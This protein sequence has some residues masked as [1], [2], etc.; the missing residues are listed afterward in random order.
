MEALR[1]LEREGWGGGRRRQGRKWEK[2]RG[3]RKRMN[4]KTI[5]SVV[6]YVSSMWASLSRL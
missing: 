3:E 1:K 6:S 2:G 5:W 4:K